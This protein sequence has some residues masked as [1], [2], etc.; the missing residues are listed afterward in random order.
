MD[1]YMNNKIKEL[2]NKKVFVILKTG[3]KYSGIIKEINN[4]LIYLED[5][6][7]QLVFFNI[8][9]ISSLEEEQ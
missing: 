5:K 1:G 6:Y 9:E 7:N 8:E 3:R 4:N 2:T